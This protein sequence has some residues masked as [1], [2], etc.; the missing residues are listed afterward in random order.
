MCVFYLQNV[1]GLHNKEKACLVFF[2]VPEVK[3]LIILSYYTVFGVV[4]LLDGAIR[5]NESVPFWEDLLTY[6][7]CQLTGYD[8]MCEDIRRQFEMHTNPGLD[9]LSHIVLAFITWVNLL[10]AIKGEDVKWLGQKVMLSCNLIVKGALH[11][12]GSSS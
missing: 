5:I 12:A 3:I 11:K 2:T 10:F 4:Q 8:P 9:F 7:K 1:A 6:F